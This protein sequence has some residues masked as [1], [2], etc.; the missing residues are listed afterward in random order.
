MK[1]AIIGIGKWGK[2]LVKEFG[3]VCEIKYACHRGNTDEAVFMRENFPN[4]K[5]T[6]NIDEILNDQEVSAV[7]VATP[8]ASHYEIAKKIV[9]SHKH[10]F[11]EKPA[12]INSTELLDI[13]QVAEQNNLIINIGYE[14]VH[15]P[16]IK[17]LEELIQR[18]NIEKIFLS[19]SKLGTFEDSA[20]L[21]LLVHEISIIKKLCPGEL[22]IESISTTNV[23]SPTDIVD[24]SFKIGNVEI[25]SHINRVSPLKSKTVTVIT[26]KDCYIW[27]NNDLYRVDKDKKTL[28]QIQVDNTS[29]LRV[30]ALDFIDCIERSKQPI[31]DSKFGIEIHEIL[32]SLPSDQS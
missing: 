7:L 27:S 5:V 25:K 14:F 13:S 3:S 19:W 4:I 29:P 18:S 32:E 26:D 9:Q 22:K 11:I 17:T 20:I 15:H 1:V 30:E 23:I 8:P 10:L 16:A 31:T 24:C 6:T 21:N 2:N 12:C 28:E